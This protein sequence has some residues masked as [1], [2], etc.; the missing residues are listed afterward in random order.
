MYH[1]I[2]HAKPTKASSQFGL[3]K[4]AYVAV[5]LDYKDLDGA[6]ELAKYYIESDGWEILELEDE[7]YLVGSKEE[8]GEGHEQYFEEVLEYGYSIVFNI[9]QDDE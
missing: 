3:A 9:Y 2:A 8:M 4:G 1:I 5:Y 7:C 6:F